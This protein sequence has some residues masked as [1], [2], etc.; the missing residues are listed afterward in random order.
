M[1]NVL[2]SGAHGLIG[3]GIIRSIRMSETPYKVIGITIFE[4]SVAPGFCD[5]VLK[6][7]LSRSEGY[8]D[9]LLSTIRD[10]RVDIVF[11]GFEDDVTIWNENIQA[12]RDTGVAV[13][14]NK[15]E[16]I[17]LCNDK[18][19]F[20]EVLRNHNFPKAI[21]TFLSADFAWLEDN[22][23]LPLLLKPRVGGASRGIVLVKDEETFNL[24]K[25]RIG[26]ELMVQPYIGNDEEEYTTAAF[27][28][29][30]GG[31]TAIM[32]M[33]R[34]LSKQGFTE[35]ATVVESPL[36]EET[37]SALCDIFKPIG[38]TNFQF[39]QDDGE[40]KLLEINPRISSA[41]S[42]RSA[43]GYNEPEMALEYYLDNKLPEQPTIRKGRA[44]RYV[45]DFIFKE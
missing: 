14:M 1:K 30:N 3:Y 11:P 18:W 26:P 24:H 8:I 23:G 32:T 17:P 21:P 41:S 19:D 10:H 22:L 15:S 6:A 38:P 36:I 27:G 9:W 25:D 37:V 34:K 43:F 29:G 42:I 31:Y 45:E 13:V 2:V 39:R 12:L 7:P 44:V 16:L 5:L 4:D 35:K 20:Y 33:K 40:F 28:D